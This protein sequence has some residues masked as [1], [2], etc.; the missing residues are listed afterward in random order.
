MVAASGDIDLRALKDNIHLLAKLKIT[1]TADEIVLSAR[2]RI[3]LNGGGSYARFDG[4]GIELGTKA[5]FDVKADLKRFMGSNAMPLPQV[6]VREMTAF[7]ERFRL[8]DEAGQPM[9]DC[10]YRVVSS[11]GMTWEG[12]SDAQGLTPHFNTDQPSKLRLEILQEAN[13]G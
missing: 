2:Q 1:Q 12:R 11:C 3:V 10:A 6:D 7:D 8:V 5:G 13:D 9:A 4:S